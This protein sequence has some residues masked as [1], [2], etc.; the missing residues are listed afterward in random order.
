MFGI[1]S[2]HNSVHLLLCIGENGEEYFP[3][4]NIEA[5]THLRCPN[6]YRA[7]TSQHDGWPNLGDRLRMASRNF[8][9][10]LDRYRILFT[11]RSNLSS[12]RVFMKM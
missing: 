8:I 12:V 2:V 11:C 7:K 1:P 5:V 4:L 10:K 9:A 6:H 3:T